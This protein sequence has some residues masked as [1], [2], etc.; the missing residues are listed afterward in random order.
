VEAEALMSLDP[1]RDWIDSF[2]AAVEEERYQIDLAQSR[3]PRLGSLFR[4]SSRLFSID[5]ITEVQRVL[6]GTGGVE[7]RQVRALLEFLGRGRAM[8]VA[9]EQLDR[10]IEWEV[11]GYVQVG[12]NRIPN[13][14]I[15][16]ALGLPAD[17]DRR[18]AIEEAH[19]TA[20]DEQHDLAADFLM[21]HRDGI[22]ELGYGSH[23]DTFQILGGIDLIGIAR[24]CERFLEETQGKFLDLLKWHLPRV[25][26]VSVAEA[27]ASDARRLEAA[28]EYDGLLPGGDRNRRILGA[29][30]GAGIDP[31]AD[32][33]ISVDWGSFLGGEAG[34]VCRTPQVPSGVRLAVST[35]SGR[36][37][38]ASF[39]RGYGYALHHAY[40]R[41]D[42]PVEQRRLG[43][44]SVARGTGALF[45]SLLRN[46]T[47]L[48]RTFEFPS[49][50]IDDYLGLA[51]LINL[52]EL[53]REIGRFLFE[54]AFYTDPGVEDAY[55]EL[56]G[57]ATGM[58]HDRRAA[59]WAVDPEFSSAR[60]I[61]AAQ[62]GATLALVL[63][64]RFD[65]DWFRNPRAGNFLQDLFADGRRYSAPELCVQVS[66]RKLTFQDILAG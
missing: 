3:N 66:S 61:R 13:R 6:A 60:R 29:L 24:D 10:K 58:R 37:A 57:R 33:R 65:L 7:E 39:M 16:A 47:F 9:A 2:L 21:R 44:D 15:A 30:G 55:V 25:A 19:Y 46:P 50:R 64:D 4:E 40:T 45:E 26:A 17:P 54:V 38:V 14:Q 22:A 23:V 52:L 35:R 31:L 48:R 53:R 41:E 18:H 63:R 34:A 49:S 42:L 8:A 43:D 12:E 59:I 56:L 5:R 27:R 20:L 51:E 1:L 36:P 32:G 11:F 28:A 62:L